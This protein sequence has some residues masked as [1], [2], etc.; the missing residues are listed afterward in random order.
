MS[1]R[2]LV[3]NSRDDGL[4]A[5]LDGP[6]MNHYMSYSQYCRCSAKLR[7][8]IGFSISINLRFLLASS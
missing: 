6:S 5:R 8:D 3:I 7:L 1:S 4:R 2:I